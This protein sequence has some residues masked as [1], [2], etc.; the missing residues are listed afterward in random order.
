[1]STCLDYNLK[2]RFVN[3]QLS[4][5]PVFLHSVHGVQTPVALNS[6]GERE[7][8]TTGEVEGTGGQGVA[9]GRVRVYARPGSLLCDPE[10]VITRVCRRAAAPRY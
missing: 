2:L 10:D 3:N 6:L 9:G 5:S 4:L 7:R 1:M 8:R